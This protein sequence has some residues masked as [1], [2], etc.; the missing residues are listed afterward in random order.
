M[1]SVSKVAVGRQGGSYLLNT[2]EASSRIKWP[3]IAKGSL[4]RLLHFIA[5]RVF[6]D[7]TWVAM[8][9]S[10]TCIDGEA[11]AGRVGKVLVGWNVGFLPAIELAVAVDT[12]DVV[13]ARGR[14]RPLKSSIGKIIGRRRGQWPG[15]VFRGGAFLGT[16]GG[17]GAR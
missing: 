2:R 1:P 9:K 14:G 13:G 10:D 15:G 3:V 11:A 16:R 7:A 8:T 17:R 5:E 12:L 4:P 6:F